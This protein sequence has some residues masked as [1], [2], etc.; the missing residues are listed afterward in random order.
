[1][2]A[3][4]KP[5]G[6]IPSG[7]IWREP[8]PDFQTVA[9]FCFN[10]PDGVHFCMAQQTLVGSVGGLIRIM[11]DRPV[12]DAHLGLFIEMTPAGIRR[13]AADLAQ[14]ADAVEA[15][16]AAAAN[17]QLAATLAARPDPAA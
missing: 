1:M 15:R 4:D 2:S 14:V 8:D 10:R 16:H 3:A 11:M 5:D 12:D 9:P 7:P 6:P 13:F 17:A